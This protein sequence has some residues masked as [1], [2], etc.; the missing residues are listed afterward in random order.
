MYG[1]LYG[2]VLVLSLAFCCHALARERGLRT[3]IFFRAM[4]YDVSGVL[5]LSDGRFAVVIHFRA[6]I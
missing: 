1:R 3:V 5:Q 2:Y 4:S 6:R